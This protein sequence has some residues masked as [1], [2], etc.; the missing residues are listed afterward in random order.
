LRTA[1]VNNSNAK[2]HRLVQVPLHNECCEELGARVN[3]SKLK[4][5]LNFRQTVSHANDLRYAGVKVRELERH[6]LEHEWQ[7]KH[8]VL[9]QGYSIVLYIFVVLVCLYIAIRL[10]LCL[11]TKGT[12]RRVAGALKL[13]STSNANPGSEGSG[14]VVNIN[15]KTSNESIALASEAMPLCTLPPSGTKDAESGTST[16]RRPC[17]LVFDLDQFQGYN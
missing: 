1:T 17:A 15:I 2:E 4:L 12:C 13:H 16:S 11:K 9:H 5:N 8:S 10:I 14:N 3:P 6:T 7:E